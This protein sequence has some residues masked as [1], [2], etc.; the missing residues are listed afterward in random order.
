MLYF[1]MKVGSEDNVVGGNTEIKFCTR[2]QA[3]MFFISLQS[4]AQPDLV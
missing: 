2:L 1:Q 3:Q 4:L